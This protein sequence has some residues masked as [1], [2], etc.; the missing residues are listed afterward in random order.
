MQPVSRHRSLRSAVV[1]LVVSV[2]SFA[3]AGAEDPGATKRGYFHDANGPRHMLISPSQFL[4]SLNIPDG[5]DVAVRPA[6]LPPRQSPPRLP[7]CAVRLEDTLRQRGLHVVHDTTVA[8]LRELPDLVFALPVLHLV[9][10]DVPIYQTDK[11]IVAFRADVDPVTI[12]E[13]AKTYDCDIQECQRG[14]NRYILRLRDTRSTS[15]LSVANALHERKDLTLYAHPDFFLPKL[16]QSPP[17]ISDPYYLSHQWHLDGDTDKGAQPGSDINVEAAWD[18]DHGPSAQGDPSVRVAILDE[19]VEKWHPDLLPN[20]A[21][22]IDLDVQPP[23]DDPSPDGGQRHGTSCAGVAVAAGN[24][25]GVR[26]AAPNCGLIGVKFFGATI[27]E[28]ADGFYFSVDPNDD[29]DHGD[30]AAVLSNSWSFADGTLLPPDVVNAINYAAINGRDGLGCLVLFAAANNDH[31]VNGVT[32]LA[33]METTMAIGGTN[34]NAAHTEFSDVGPEVGVVAPTNDRGDDG[35]RFSWLDITTVDNTGSSGYNGLPDLDYTNQFGGTSSATPLAAGVFALIISQD[36]TMTAAQARAI[37]QHTAV[38]VDPPYGRFDGITGHSHRL[39]FG[40]VDAAAAVA[41]AHAGLRWPDRIKT[42]SATADGD[43]VMLVWSTPLAGYAGSLLVRSDKPFDWMPIDGAT[44]T[45]GQTVAPDVQVIYTD[46]ISTHLDVGASSGGFFYAIYPYSTEMLYGFGAKTHIFRDAVSLF[47]DNSE[48]ASPGWT[49]GGILDEWTRG[50]PTSGVSIFGQSVY[51]SGP[52]AGLNG[53]RAIGGDNCWGTDLNSTYDAGTDAWLQTPLINL[54]GVSVPIFLEYY[55]WCML[56]TFYDTCSIEIVDAQDNLVGVVDADTAGDY[57][58]TQ[59]VYDLSPFAG[60]PIKIR[61]HIVADGIFQR[62]GWFIDEVRIVAAGDGPLPPVAD[63]IYVETAENSPVSVI[64]QA[65]DPN[66]GDIL[67]Y[68]ITSLPAHGQL[69][70]PNAG[71]ITAVPTTLLSD[72]FVVDFTPTTDYQGP[73]AFAYRAHDGLLDS[74]QAT[75]TL[76]IG[77]PQP[78]YVDSLDVDPGWITQ[79][80]WAFGQPQGNSGDPTTGATGLNVYGY[81]LAGAYQDDMPPRYLT[82]LPFNCSGLSRVT[83]NFARWLG[84]EAGSYDK[85]TI[86]VSADGI[87]WATVWSYGGAEDLEEAEWSQQSYNIAAWADDQPFILIRWAMGPTDGSDTFAGW[88]IDDVSISAIGTPPTNQP[89]Y[90]AD[91]AA[92]TAVDQTVDISLNAIDPDADP[93]DYTIQSLPL[94]GVLHDPN[95]G[96]I[97][98]APYVLLSHGSVVSY[99]PNL[100]YSG[101]DS[102]EYVADDGLLISNV[103]TTSIEVLYPAVFPFIEDFESGPPPAAYWHTHSTNT[104]RIQITPENGPIGAYHATLDSTAEGSYSLNE[105]TLVADLAGQSMVIFEYDWRDFGDE[106]HTLPD[107]WQDSAEGDG[108]AISADGVTWYR[109][110]DLFDGDRGG[111]EDGGERGPRGE[112]YQTV[113]ID[114]DDVVATVGISYTT[115]FRIRF[116]QY[117]NYPIDSDGIALDNVRLTQGTEDPLIATGSLPA[118]RLSEPYGPISLEAIGGDEPLVWSVLDVYGESD[119]GASEFAAVGIAQGWHDDD[120][121][122][123]YTLP[124]AFPFWG[125]LLTDVKIGTDGWINFGP[126]VGSTYNNSTVLLRYNKRIAALWDDLRTDEGGDIFIDEDTPAQVTIRWD[127]STQ[128]GGTPCNFSA[129]LYENGNIRFHYGSGNTGLT[130]TIG[131]SAGDGTSDRY[132]LTSYDG[133]TE[134]TDANSLEIEWLSLPPGMVMSQE[135]IIEGVPTEAGIYRPIFHVSDALDR[136]D[137]KQIPIL[138]TDALLGDFDDDGDVDEDDF[139][140]FR[141]CYTGPDGGPVGPSCEAGDFDGDNDVDC[142][143]Y[144]AFRAAFFDSSG[145][146]PTMDISEFV[147]ALLDP[148]SDEGDL[149]IA[150]MNVSGRADGNDIQAFVQALLGG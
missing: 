9:G 72:G 141:V 68:V 22:G 116:Q 140:Q 18:S 34:S 132:L 95:G 126:Y 55:D 113:R 50:V 54:S 110:A 125:E 73:D 147:A 26:G 96:L 61:F 148:A 137:S 6:C 101:M 123:D 47:Y 82:M 77:T 41:A 90:A 57:D 39:G 139:S 124:F 40:R 32:A 48:G 122:F 128:A 58:W 56:E 76:S 59:H 111:P 97:D 94:A 35:V 27:S 100:L 8:E 12:D 112:Q 63:D 49:H 30:G 4:V 121:A 149:C 45:V 36:P 138:V 143:D 78:V 142:D 145:Y 109:I 5:R 127:A 64:L 17:V 102:F 117:D 70:D 60:Q 20:W 31:T 53:T 114:L 146:G 46:I 65:T 37:A 85:A 81:N 51:G 120:T 91:V 136:T 67:A 43:T 150:D 42:I 92:S 133:L 13:I 1:G 107:V 93:V 25:I 14:K 106:A 15:P 87:Q 52:L 21:A 28:M 134:L 119:L 135:G 71:P 23:D 131:I 10:S 98:V 24:S 115:T 16:T 104:G 86:E 130:P 11:I 75:V 118:A 108:V 103:A 74:N 29:G 83:L 3:A 79:G 84:V 80:D 105:L 7:G 69:S 62:D 99:Q 89:P 144:Q 66:P 2:T 44:Y 88:N 129:T 38:P 19:C 33:Q